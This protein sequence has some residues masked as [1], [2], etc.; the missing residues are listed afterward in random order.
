MLTFLSV[1]W[2]A[3]M[4]AAD[5]SSLTVSSIR[6]SMSP[7]GLSWT[8]YIGFDDVLKDTRES[9]VADLSISY[10]QM[11]SLGLTDDEIDTR[12]KAY[13]FLRSTI[14]S[15]VDRGIPHRAHCPEK[16]RRNLKK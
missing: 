5:R 1:L 4:I 13:Q 11:R 16:A 3:T 14:T 8:N 2:P 10:A 7:M 12:R 6:Y 15:E 9:P